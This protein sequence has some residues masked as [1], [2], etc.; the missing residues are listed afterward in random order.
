VLFKVEEEEA[1]VAAAFAA[2]TTTR[3][4]VAKIKPKGISIRMPETEGARRAH[5]GEAPWPS[6][7]LLPHPSRDG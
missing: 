1:P 7:R 3:R 2:A 4:Q 6:R 5:G